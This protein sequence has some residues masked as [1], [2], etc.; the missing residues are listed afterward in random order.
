MCVCMCVRGVCVCV[1]VYE[2]IIYVSAVYTTCTMYSKTI[3][4][5][6]CMLMHS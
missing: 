3:H 5:P 4:I 2:V 1:Q 6:V